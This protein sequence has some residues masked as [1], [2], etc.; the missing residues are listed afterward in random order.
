MKLLF[1]NSQTQK[2]LTMEEVFDEIGKIIEEGI[3]LPCY[4]SWS[5][6]RYATEANVESWTEF[7]PCDKGGV[8]HDS[9][10]DI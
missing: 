10:R 7:F 1:Y 9:F 4:R 8:N 6:D 5:K 3:L 2:T